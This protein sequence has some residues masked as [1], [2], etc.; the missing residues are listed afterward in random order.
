MPGVRQD[1]W[2]QASKIAIGLVLGAGLGAC[3]TSGLSSSADSTP[4]GSSPSYTERF[5]QLFS[6]KP[7]ASTASASGEEPEQTS[8]YCPT[9]DVRAGASTLSV[10][11]SSDPT[12][13]QLRYQGTLGQTARECSTA[14]GNLT[15]KVGVQGRLI[16]GPAG[17]PGTLDVP[18]RYALVQE[19]PQPKTIW[20]KLYRFPVTINEGQASV[21]FTHV[22]EDMI[23]PKPR[24][25]DLES[26]VVYIG[27]D[28]I[29][30]RPEPK[31]PAAP[32]KPKKR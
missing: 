11:A 27:F 20:T 14:G 21:P 15:I 26:Y 18:L 7:S 6:S 5:T 23:V 16:L 9:V 3:S 22:E 10:A 25:I 4:S 24:A 17:T 30:G 2:G 13:M 1:W 19:G 31:K 12:A 8:G 32:Q 28:A 29:A